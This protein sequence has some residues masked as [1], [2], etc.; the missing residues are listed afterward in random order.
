M[1]DERKKAFCHHCDGD[2]NQEIV[3]KETEFDTQEVFFESLKGEPRWVVEQREWEITKCLGCDY[4]NLDIE[5]IH[6]GNKNT[7]TQKIP[8]GS[9][10]KVPSWIFGLDRKYIEIL[11]EVYSAFNR[12]LFRL[13]LMGFRTVID[14]YLVEKVGDK[15]SFVSKLKALEQQ[16]LI[17]STQKKLLDVA[18]D[19]GNASSHRGYSPSEQTL[20]SIADIIEHL[21][22]ATILEKRIE[23]ISSATPPRPKST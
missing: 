18:V 2:T 3:F 9:I 15:G 14:M 6:V 4:L 13:T 8:G 11:A 21:L 22:N 20:Q 23:E 19:A 12:G 1:K 5:T 16:G 7:G 17:S 10:R